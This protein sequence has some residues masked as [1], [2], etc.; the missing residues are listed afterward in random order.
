LNRLAGFN[1][2]RLAVNRG[3]SGDSSMEGDSIDEKGIE[4]NLFRSV[5]A[6]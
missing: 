3:E 2:P 1:L 4:A 6:P 5:N